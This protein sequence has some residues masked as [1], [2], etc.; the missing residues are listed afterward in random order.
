[1]QKAE[2]GR[3]TC[4]GQPRP[5]KKKKRE[6]ETEKIMRPHLSGKKPDVAHACPSSCGK[7]HK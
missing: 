2:I 4:P 6:R 7:Q 5:K 3:I 1:M